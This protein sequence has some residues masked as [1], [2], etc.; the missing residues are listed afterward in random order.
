MF[1]RPPYQNGSVPGNHTLRKGVLIFLMGLVLPSLVTA[2]LPGRSQYHEFGGTRLTVPF[3]YDVPDC[4]GIRSQLFRKK[5]THPVPVT[6]LA[7]S[8]CGE[9]V[10]VQIPEVN[11]PSHYELVIEV[12]KGS[13]WHHLDTIAITGFPRDIFKDFRKWA[14]NHEVMVAD[15][16][17]KLESFLKK[18]EIPFTSSFGFEPPSPQAIMKVGEREYVFHET[19]TPFP[20][21]WIRDKQVVFELRFLDQLPTNPLAQNELMQVLKQDISQ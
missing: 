9:D 6:Q 16:E 21:I 11:K 18:Q 3:N 2:A 12:Q 17:G 19:E 14:E 15:S 13:N 10:A 4:S 7:L 8:Q 1:A 5:N 20:K